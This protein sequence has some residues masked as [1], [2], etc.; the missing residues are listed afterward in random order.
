MTNYDLNSRYFEWMYSK[1]FGEESTQL[2]YRRLLNEL[3]HIPFRFNWDEDEPRMLDGLQLRYRFARENHY[4]DTLIQSYFGNRP[5]SVLEMM[6]A[7][8]VKCEE[9][10]LDDPDFGDHTSLM[11]LNMLTSLGLRTMHDR[12][13]DSEYIYSKVSKF[14]DRDYAYNGEGGLFTIRDPQKDMRTVD[15]WYQMCA[16]LCEEIV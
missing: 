11:F 10:I 2:S 9:T 5:C 1:A 14:L 12:R 7:L 16:Y 8:S 3:D 4:D 13:F 15:I 6:L